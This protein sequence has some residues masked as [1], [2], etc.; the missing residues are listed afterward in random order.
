MDYYCDAENTTGLVICCNDI[1]YPAAD[2]EDLPSHK[3][4]EFYN[5]WK[6]D[7]VY[8]PIKWISEQRNIMPMPQITEKMTKLGLWNNV[9]R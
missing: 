5:Y 6:L 2:A 4:E 8:G 9:I 3:I 1:F 7:H